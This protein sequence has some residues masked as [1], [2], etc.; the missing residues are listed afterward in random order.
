MGSR[1]AGIA[2]V[3][4]G[5]GQEALMRLVMTTAVGDEPAVVE[6]H[7]A[8]HLNAGVDFVI[9]TSGESRDEMAEILES[10]VRQ[11]HLRVLATGDDSWSLVAEHAP[12]WVIASDSSE[13]WW[14]RGESLK[15]VL[16]AI[17]ARYTIVQALVRDF[18]V[19]RDDG[20]FFA[21]RM[22]A[23]RVVRPG[24]EGSAT[25]RPLV[26]V[27]PSR[28]RSSDR[29]VPLRGWYPVEVLRFES[30]RAERVL[31]DDRLAQGLADGSLVS[32][33]RLRDALRTLRGGT[34]FTPERQFALPGEQPG[35]LIFKRPDIVEDAAYAVECAAVGEVD[36]ARLE[37]HIDELERRIGWLEQR[38]WPRVLRR[39]SRS[40]GGTPP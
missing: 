12:D 11:G 34:P 39:L 24:D 3:T 35:P 21:E 13:F 6:A 29:Q 14:P 4:E 1:I 18:P 37:R 33:T 25:L 5:G 8:Y 10:H 7:I 26:R 17:P 22:T 36:V 15:D 31:D 2:G 32:D 20:T 16:A 28:E 23:R 38:L 40:V 19:C 9:A 27:S 30:D